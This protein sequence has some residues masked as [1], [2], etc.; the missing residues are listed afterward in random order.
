M[1]NIIQ[2]E[3]NYYN[4]WNGNDIDNASV[5]I[6]ARGKCTTD[7]ISMTGPWLKYRGHLDNISNNCLIGA[8]NDSNGKENNILNILTN[9]QDNTVPDTARNYK[10]NNIALRGL[11]VYSLLYSTTDDALYSIFSEYGEL[12][13]AVIIKD[14]NNSNKSKGYYGI[15]TYADGQCYARIN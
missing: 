2:N 9:K 8:I 12:E 10:S 11:F 4:A 3:Y 1:I 5:L 7:H 13:E 15:G 14:K 6:K